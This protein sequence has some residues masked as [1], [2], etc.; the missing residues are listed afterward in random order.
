MC[1]CSPFWAFSSVTFI[2]ATQKTV[3]FRTLFRRTGH[4]NGRRR[5]RRRRLSWRD[6]AGWRREAAQE[7]REQRIRLSHYHMFSMTETSP[8]AHAPQRSSSSPPPSSAYLY[9]GDHPPPPV[10]TTSD[11]GTEA[12]LMASMGLPTSLA[13]FTAESNKDEV[14]EVCRKQADRQRPARAHSP[15]ALLAGRSGAPTPPK[16]RRVLRSTRRETTG[17]AAR[18]ERRSPHQQRR[19]QQCHRPSP[20]V[21]AHQRVAMNRSEGV[22]AGVAVASAHAMPS[23]TQRQLSA[24][25]R[26]QRERRLS[27]RELRADARNCDSP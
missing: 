4:H 3:C 23:R 14:Y 18:A 11:P 19:T 25:I 21:A 13:A 15:H 26:G 12:A 20:A 24:Q 7:K 17:L 2:V 27:R 16:W 6:A 22:E 9:S 1:S 8:A 5:R 10:P